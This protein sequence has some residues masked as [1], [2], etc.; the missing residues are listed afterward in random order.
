MDG[1]WFWGRKWQCGI[2]SHTGTEFWVI[3][4]VFG[5]SSDEPRVGLFSK[6]LFSRNCHIPLK[7]FLRWVLCHVYG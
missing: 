7:M 4:T 5:L 3:G 1:F 2:I 6:L